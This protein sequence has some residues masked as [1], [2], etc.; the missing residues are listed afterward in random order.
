MRRKPPS[1]TIRMVL[2]VIRLRCPR[3]ESPWHRQVRHHVSVAH[4]V[5]RVAT[6]LLT[7]QC[8]SDSRSPLHDFMA[9]LS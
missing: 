7:R 1:L 9:D 2:S 5:F 6:A 8:M 3:I 4:V